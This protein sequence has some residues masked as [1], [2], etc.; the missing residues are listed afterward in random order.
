MDRRPIPVPTEERERMIAPEDLAEA[1]R[2]VAALP[3]RTTIPEML[4]MPTHRREH[5]PGETG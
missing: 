5:K 3:P 1:V 4:L 2:F